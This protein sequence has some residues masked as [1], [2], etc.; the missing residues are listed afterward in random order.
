M[1]PSSF[2]HRVSTDHRSVPPDRHSPPPISSIPPARFTPIIR[3]Q[4]PLFSLHSHSARPTIL[5]TRHSATASPITSIIIDRQALPHRATRRYGRCAHRSIAHFSYFARSFR[6]SSRHSI[7]ITTLFT[8]S[9]SHHNSGLWICSDHRHYGFSSSVHNNS[10]PFP[11][12]LGT[13]RHVPIPGVSGIGNSG[14]FR[15]WIPQLF[16]APSGSGSGP[17]A[18]TS[19]NGPGRHLNAP[20]LSGIPSDFRAGTGSVRHGAQASAYS[21]T[22]TGKSIDRRAFHSHY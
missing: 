16:N 9:S 6:S 15:V 5:L 12:P 22:V 18:I 10:A 20:S 4:Q 7:G 21:S 19:G 2:H 17:G 8:Q 3:N 1:P 13:G 11:N 14:Q